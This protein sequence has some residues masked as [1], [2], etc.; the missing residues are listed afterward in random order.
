MAFQEGNAGKSTRQLAGKRLQ[1][2][3][4][5]LLI[6]FIVSSI[7]LLLL[8]TKNSLFLLGFFFLLIP[9]MKQWL[10][11]EFWKYR[12]LK[13][14]TLKGAKAE[15][16]IG[17]ILTQLP[18]GYAIFHDVLSSHGN[19]DHVILSRNQGIFLLETKSH[20]GI[21]TSNKNKLYINGNMPEKDFIEQTHNNVLWLKNILKKDADSHI[22]II[23]II[24][25][26]NAFVKFKFYKPISGISVINKK[27][28]L[29]IILD[30]P[31]RNNAPTAKIYAV[32]KQRLQFREE[33]V[34]TH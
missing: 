24:V 26:T 22:N 8:A 14:R 33:T 17:G 29:K 20:H 10:F 4:L 25:F 7:F 32:L 5:V 18:K 31:D 19:I 21:V 30:W 6:F 2:N 15:E 28:L 27:I 11:R 16:E 3:V 13:P 1:T 9:F 12:K 34:I 23:P